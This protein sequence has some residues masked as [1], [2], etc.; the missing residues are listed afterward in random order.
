MKLEGVTEDVDNSDLGKLIA[1][2][3]GY[4]SKLEAQKI[5]ERTM[6]GRRARAAAGRISSGSGMKIYGYNYVPVSQENGGR[7]IINETE[8]KWVRQ[9]YEWLVNGGLST[10]AITLRLSD[11]GVLS[12]TGK[13]M[14][15]RA[16]CPYSRTRPTRAHGLLRHRD[17]RGDT[18]DHPPGAVRRRPEATSNQ[19]SPVAASCQAPVPT[20]RPYPMSPMRPNL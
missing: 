12:K 19:L 2:I 11:F 3:K 18:G 6:R 9:M 20:P 10:N 7:R 14:A 16:S 17:T 15:G 13:M 1:Y 5:R 8:A 4:A